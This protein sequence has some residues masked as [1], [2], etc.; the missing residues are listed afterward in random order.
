M[1]KGVYF[2]KGKKRKDEGKLNLGKGKRNA[3]GA[4]IK[5]KC[6]VKRILACHQED[7]VAGI[8]HLMCNLY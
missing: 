1:P 4:K 2:G 8:G 3:N 7:I 5:A 6:R